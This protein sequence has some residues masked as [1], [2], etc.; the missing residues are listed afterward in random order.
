MYVGITKALGP[1]QSK[2]AP[3]K[4]ISGEV[5]NDQGEKM[6]RWVEHYSELYSRENSVVDPLLDAIGP[7]PIMEDLDAEPTLE[8]LN[9]AI[10]SLACG[11]APGTDGIPPDPIKRCKSTLLQPL[12]DTLCQC[13]REGGVPQDMKDAKIVTLYKNNGDRSDCNNYRGIFLLSIVGKVYAR[14]MPRAYSIWLNMSESQCNT[15]HDFL[16]LPTPGEM[17]GTTETP[18]HCL[19]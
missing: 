6:E 14:V 16:L 10:D 19:H 1:T 8:E 18:L 12:H 13:W 11:K 9:K 3:L 7:L 17:Q 2:T 5:I 4:S 15:G